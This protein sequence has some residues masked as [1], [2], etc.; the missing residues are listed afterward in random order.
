MGKK[1]PIWEN[2]N[3]EAMDKKRRAGADPTRLRIYDL[4][5]RRP[6]WTAKDLAS[7]LGVSPNGL[8]YH[9]RIM[10]DAGL[11]K[12]VRTQVSGR[13]A[14][15]VYGADDLDQRVIWDSKDPVQ[16][17]AYMT[18]T[19]DAGKVGAEDAIY[20]MARD[21]EANEKDE[22]HTFV[23]WGGPAIG[24][25]PEEVREFQKRLHELLKEFRERAKAQAG[26]GV[27]RGE[28]PRLRFVYALYEQKPLRKRA[29]STPSELASA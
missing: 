7:E 15:R 25:S 1:D 10:Q 3:T 20:Q 8:Y 18:A 12:V 23:D 14:E 19:L 11:I 22:Q 13:M 17:A 5:W 24:T 9:L 29:E 2:L 28:G 4:F 26:E 16:M 21:L 27:D 6:E